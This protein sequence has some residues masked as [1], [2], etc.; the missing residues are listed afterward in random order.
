[1]DFSSILFCKI[2][3]LK[4]ILSFKNISKSLLLRDFIN[5]KTFLLVIL[6]N[7]SI[8]CISNRGNFHFYRMITDFL[9]STQDHDD[10]ATVFL[11]TLDFCFSLIADF[12][13]INV[14]MDT[15]STSRIITVLILTAF[16]VLTTNSA[17]ATINHAEV[18]LGIE[19]TLH[20]VKYVLTVSLCVS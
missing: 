17:P 13:L 15:K 4:K 6:Q 14:T 16:A 10:C 1:L 8:H 5:E 12:I 2:L 18:S 9:I 3:H 7:L 19:Y 11:N 20:R